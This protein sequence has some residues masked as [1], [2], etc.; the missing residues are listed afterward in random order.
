ME[1]YKLIAYILGGIYGLCVG[2]FLNVVIY[3]LPLGMSLAKPASHCPRCGYRLKASDNIPVLSYLLL[4]GRCRACRAPISPRYTIVELLNMILWLF[5]VHLF[6]DR[7]LV[8]ACVVALCASVM[9][10]IFF[11]DLAHMLIPDS[12]NLAL[13]ALGVLAVFFDPDYGW[14][15]HL[16]GLCVGF[17][18]FYGVYA[19]FYYGFGKD[20]LGGGDIKLAAAAG[21][22]LGWER[23]LLGLILS[24]VSAAIVLSILSR[25]THAE[26]DR[27]YPFGPFLAVGFLLALYLGAP[28]INAYLGLL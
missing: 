18:F 20:A 4:R 9:I 3:R 25:R 10:S 8:F 22:L 17:F 19:L 11:I 15:S 27:E 24:S 6:Y 14:Q 28:F 23:L 13:L 21:L 16:I 7:G 26:R 5:A 12:L 2:S 1:Y